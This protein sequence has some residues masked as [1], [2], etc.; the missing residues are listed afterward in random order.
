MQK[1]ISSFF[2]ITEHLQNN[3]LIFFTSNG[4][5]IGDLAKPVDQIY[6]TEDA[7]DLMLL[8]YSDSNRDNQDETILLKNTEYKIGNI[9]LKSKFSVLNV[10]Q[11]ISFQ[12]GSKSSLKEILD[13]Y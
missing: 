8:A 9:I 1:A 7:D 11:I 3:T 5:I 13:Q 6:D 4:I 12:V 2:K 10:N